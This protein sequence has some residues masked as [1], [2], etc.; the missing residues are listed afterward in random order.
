MA[1]VAEAAQP[2]GNVDIGKIIPAIWL[3]RDEFEPAIGHQ[4]APLLS[5]GGKVPIDLSQEP[6]ALHPF[7]GRIARNEARLR[8][9]VLKCTILAK[10]VG[11]LLD[12]ELRPQH[13]RIIGLDG[14]LKKIGIDVAARQRFRLGEIDPA[15][16]RL[17]GDLDPADTHVPQ[18][19][20]GLH[21]P[22]QVAVLGERAQDVGP[23]RQQGIKIFAGDGF[24][25]A[26]PVVVHETNRCWRLQEPL[27]IGSYSLV[28]QQ[29]V[30]SL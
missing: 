26:E 3:P 15:R 23:A 28:H 11:V 29:F 30:R 24:C 21:G 4:G 14:D 8:P 12:M 22:A 9:E 2:N 20:P 19:T 6:D 10:E 27:A 13:A 7:A 16:S 5:A 1:G 18:P 25:R 17:R